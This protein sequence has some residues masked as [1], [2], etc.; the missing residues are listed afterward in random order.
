MHH[1]KAQIRK[2]DNTGQRNGKGFSK[3]EV[4]KADLN[5]VNARKMGLPV[6]SRRRTVHDKNIEVIKAH[7][8][9]QKAKVKPKPKAVPSTKKEKPKR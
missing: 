2:P 9:K 8:E 6:D 4:K 1:V 3:G 7:A 5:T